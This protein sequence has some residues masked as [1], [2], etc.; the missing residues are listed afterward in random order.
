MPSNQGKAFPKG[1]KPQIDTFSQKCS[2]LKKKILFV[3]LFVWNAPALKANSSAHTGLFLE[4]L[5]E[6]SLVICSFGK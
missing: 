3:C 1:L 6:S 5:E 4:L 2:A